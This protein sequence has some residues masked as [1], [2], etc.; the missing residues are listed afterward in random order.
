M[1]GFFIEVQMWS[2]MM[3][4]VAV[5]HLYTYSVAHPIVHYILSL[6]FIIFCRLVGWY[7]C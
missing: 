7:C 2:Y 4:P 3:W 6:F 5:V 1:T